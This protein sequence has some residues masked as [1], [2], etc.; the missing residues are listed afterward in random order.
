MKKLINILATVVLATSIVPFLAKQYIKTEL[1][2]TPKQYQQIQQYYNIGENPKPSTDEEY[3]KNFQNWIN[4]NGKA[5]EGHY[6][7]WDSYLHQF[8]ESGNTDFLFR[9]QHIKAT[10]GGGVFLNQSEPN[11]FKPQYTNDNAVGSF[12]YNSYS[13]TEHVHVD[14]EKPKPSTSPITYEGPPVDGGYEGTETNLTVNDLTP[15]NPKESPQQNPNSNE[16]FN[17]LIDGYLTAILN[18]W[19]YTKFG[20]DIAKSMDPSDYALK[21]KQY[22]DFY[23]NVIDKYL[24][25]LLRFEFGAKWNDLEKIPFEEN[26][27]EKVAGN[28]LDLLVDG[29][30]E[31]AGWGWFA[32]WAA[33]V[34]LGWLMDGSLTK[35]ATVDHQFKYISP[36]FDDGTIQKIFGDILGDNSGSALPLTSIIKEFINKYGVLPDHLTLKNFD[37]S[38]DDYSAD[39]EIRKNYS[40]FPHTPSEYPGIPYW[41]RSEKDTNTTN[42]NTTKITPHISFDIAADKAAPSYKQEKEDIDDPNFASKDTALQVPTRGQK[43][44]GDQK[45]WTADQIDEALDTAWNFGADFKNYVTFVPTTLIPNQPVVVKM[46]CHL[47][48]YTKGVPS[49]GIVD[50]PRYFYAEAY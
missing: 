25:K 43:V 42:I 2:D 36:V 49:K 6:N 15:N 29:L 3:S 10:V 39:H 23:N 20:D 14:H 9:S 21:K 4:G 46:Y 1:Q 13:K 38:A 8:N 50:N 19:Y 47:L 22:T 48:G 5:T 26:K 7:S 11:T 41:K 34:G 28:F 16:H 35:Y 31:F 17:N 33:D 18:Y 40:W 12:N 37:F 27:Y 30:G 32:S 24:S 44:S 45:T